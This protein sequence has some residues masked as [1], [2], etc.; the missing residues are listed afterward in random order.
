MNSICVAA[1]IRMMMRKKKMAKKIKD[2]LDDKK[3]VESVGAVGV[4]SVS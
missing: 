1:L 4:T 3:A 2:K